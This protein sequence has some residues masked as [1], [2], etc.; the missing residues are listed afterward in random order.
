MRAADRAIIMAYRHDVCGEELRISFRGWVTHEEVVDCCV[1]AAADPRCGSLRFAVIDLSAVERWCGV[2]A[3][4]TFIAM[5]SRRLVET[6]SGKANVFMIPPEG[7]AA[8]E[9]GSAE[10]VGFA[11]ICDSDRQLREKVAALSRAH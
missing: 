10:H 7:P 11:E 1:A 6:A 9:P 4:L 8:F 5:G 3:D 2:P